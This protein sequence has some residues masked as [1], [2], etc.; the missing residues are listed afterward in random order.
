MT[1]PVDP[2]LQNLQNLQFFISSSYPCGYL[3]N[4]QAQSLIAAPHYLIDTEVYSALIRLGF[5]R[6]GQ[7]TYRP[8]CKNCS[9]CVPVR[10]PVAE[11]QPSRSQRRAWNRHQHLTTSILEPQLVEEHYA[12]YRA[13]QHAR[14]PEGGMDNDDVGQYRSFLTQSNV[15]TVLIE[16]REDDRLRMVSVVDCLT[17]GLSAVYTFY[18]CSDPTASYGTYNVLW[19]A[20]W[21]R[22]MQLPHLYLGY[23]IENSP[24]MA[25]KKNFR[26]LQALIKGHW[27]NL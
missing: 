18:A 13:Y 20:E 3:E 17:D 5:R 26:P 1:L 19:L 14:H 25:Y 7:H 21:C 22:R 10:L 27:K 15:D 24:K 2:H 11:L 6:S 8:H 9:A 23:W 16:F 4:R 12:L